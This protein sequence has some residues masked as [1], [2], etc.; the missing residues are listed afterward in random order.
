MKK[1]LLILLIIACNVTIHQPFLSASEAASKPAEN[2]S[3]SLP[4][5]ATVLSSA[6]TVAL[7][8]IGALTTYGCFRVYNYLIRDPRLAAVEDRLRS[9][10]QNVARADAVNNRF[11]DLT[12]RVDNFQNQHKQDHAHILSALEVLRQTTE[13][14]A[15][16][17][18]LLAS[19]ARVTQLIENYFKDGRQSLKKKTSTNNFSFLKN[20]GI[21]NGSPF[22]FQRLML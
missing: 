2:T 18:D 15:T 6:N 11:D 21:P 14:A 22:Q 20:P 1:N 8:S 3:S 12:I 17:N 4:S 5:F 10:E 7:I 16:K 19:E 9:L 13:Q